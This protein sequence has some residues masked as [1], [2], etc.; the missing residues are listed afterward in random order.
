MNT[1][2]E[3]IGDSILTLTHRKAVIHLSS[4]ATANQA[5]VSSGISRD[6]S[7]KISA[8]IHSL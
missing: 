3:Y 6:Q 1:T 7:G 2:P 4:L 5:A 8:E